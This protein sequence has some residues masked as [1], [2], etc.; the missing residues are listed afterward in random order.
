VNLTNTFNYTPS[1]EQP[2]RPPIYDT[3]CPE[4]GALF[5]DCKQ[6]MGPIRMNELIETALEWL[7]ERV[8]GDPEVFAD[9]V[10]RDEG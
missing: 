2:S 10:L 9:E 4:D 6:R 7:T 1:L 3:F 5:V 8:G